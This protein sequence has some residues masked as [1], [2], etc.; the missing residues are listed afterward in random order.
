ME[1]PKNP[2]SG[3]TQPQPRPPE[4][5]ERNNLQRPGGQDDRSRSGKPGQGSV[6]NMPSKERDDEGKVGQDTDG[7]GKVVK[8]GQRPGQS[9]G[10]HE[11]N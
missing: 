6:S 1:D 4:G 9:G 5:K 11:N 10:P 2:Q 3:Q 7:D 8:P